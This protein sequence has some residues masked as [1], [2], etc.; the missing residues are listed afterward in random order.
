MIQQWWTLNQYHHSGIERMLPLS[1]KLPALSCGFFC[2]RALPGSYPD[3]WRSAVQPFIAG[4]LAFV[5]EF[6]EFASG[7]DEV[8]AVVDA[9]L[10][11]LGAR[12]MG[13]FVCEEMG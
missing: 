9:R 3:T 6:E 2:A 1:T 5:L 13:Q 7:G 10:F 12:G 11:E 8:V 4:L